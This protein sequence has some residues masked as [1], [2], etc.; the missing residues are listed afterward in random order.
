MIKLIQNNLNEFN[1]VLDNA[2]IYDI[3]SQVSFLIIIRIQIKF[4]NLSDN[5]KKY[6]KLLIVQLLI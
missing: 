3:S 2:I 6:F 1:K 5:R 4:E